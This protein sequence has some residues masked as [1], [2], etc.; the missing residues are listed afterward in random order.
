[1]ITPSP[2]NFSAGG[3]YDFQLM[4]PIRSGSNALHIDVYKINAIGYDN[5]PSVNGSSL[6]LSN[7]QI[8]PVSMSTPT[9]GVYVFDFGQNF[10]GWCQF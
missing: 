8:T 10:A 4:D 9:M 7:G 6:S 2:V 3:Q 1:M 5:I